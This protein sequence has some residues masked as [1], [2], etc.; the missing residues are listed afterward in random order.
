V[1]NCDCEI[2]SEVLSLMPRKGIFIACLLCAC[3]SLCCPTKLSS[4]KLYSTKL[5]STKVSSTKLNST[6]FNPA[7]SLLLLR[8]TAQSTGQI[9]IPSHSKHTRRPNPASDARQYSQ[10]DQ[11]K[12][13]SQLF[14]K[15]FV[16]NRVGWWW[17]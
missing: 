9:P 16:P 15:R 5:F 13:D 6:H 8:S 12:P 1:L 4:T 10:N 3:R 14:P 17:W 11:F 2:V 7:H